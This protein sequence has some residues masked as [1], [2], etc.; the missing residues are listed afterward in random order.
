MGDAILDQNF[1]DGGFLADFDAG[2]D[3]GGADGIGD[4]AGA[5]AAETPGA[6]SAVNFAH[7]MV[8]QNV[9]G[10]GR[11]NAEEGADD[12]GGGHGGFEDIGFKPLVEEIGGAHGHEL[13]EIVFVFGF[14]ILE[15]LAE[16]GEFFEVARIER[17]G[18][19]RNHGR[20]WV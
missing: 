19:R 11:T 14:E 13:D 2:F 1:C 4:G 10:A 6:E 20:G 3:G 8:E 15:A 16:E 9:S 5:A 12:A 18:I 17:S 7:V